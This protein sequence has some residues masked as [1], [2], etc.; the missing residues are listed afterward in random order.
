[1]PDT[2]TA[3]SDGSLRYAGA[4]SDSM[5]WVLHDDAGDLRLFSKLRPEGTWSEM[6]FPGDGSAGVTIAALDDTTALAV[7][8]GNG[9][10]ESAVVRGDSVSLI[11]LSEFNK[12]VGPKS[13][14]LRSHPQGGY[15][16]AWDHGQPYV[17]LA[18]FLDGAWSVPESLHCAYLD[19]DQYIGE[20]PDVSQDDELHPV[21]A[22]SAYSTRTG[23]NVICVTCPTDSGYPVAEELPQINGGFLASP[24]RDE[25]GDIWLAWWKYYDGAFWIHSYTNV[26][27]IDAIVSGSPFLRNV[28]WTL[29]GP[30]PQSWWSI[31]RADEGDTTFALVGRVQAGS[32]T[33]VTWSDSSTTD[34][35]YQYR[36]R[37]D[38]KDLNYQL[39]SEPI[40]SRPEGLSWLPL[41]L[42]SE[43]GNPVRGVARVRVEGAAPGEVEVQ[44]FDVRGR[45][46]GSAS[47][48]AGA[49]GVV[50]L[51]P[52]WL[53]GAP[54]GKPRSGLYFALARDARGRTSRTLKLVVL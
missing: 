41:D 21:V 49:S 31:L 29:S 46:V 27:I 30:A 50:L 44:V 19:S 35:T 42:R 16:L 1:M 7:W 37:R 5:L 34:R 52:D 14:K 43:V 38:C 3:S 45:R 53:E 26:T 10:M 24:A 23:R 8:A 2:L 13:P 9:A 54:N 4:A 51:D 32:T 36:I 39:L 33:A 18:R 11:P 25:N 20:A 40:V 15:W 47:G 12:G 28:S 22:W 6:Q 48:R 17:K